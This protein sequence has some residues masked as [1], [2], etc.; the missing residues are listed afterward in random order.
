M[1]TKIDPKRL[2]ETIRNDC[3]EDRTTRDEKKDNKNDKK[4][5]QEVIPHIGESFFGAR[6]SLGKDIYQRQL[7]NLTTTRDL[8]RLLA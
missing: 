7:T 4:R 3:Q 5:Q 2:Q 8:T 6:G 1:E